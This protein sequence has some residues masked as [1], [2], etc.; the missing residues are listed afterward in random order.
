MLKEKENLLFEAQISKK[1]KLKESIDEEFISF[2]NKNKNTSK[3]KLNKNFT[4]DLK[5]KYYN[6]F[7]PIFMVP[8]MS[9]FANLIFT[10]ENFNNYLKEIT[11]NDNFNTILLSIFVTVIISLISYYLVKIQNVITFKFCNKLNL[12]KKKEKIIEDLFNEQ[13]VSL[14]L[15]KNISETVGE[16]KTSKILSFY[17]GLI[18]N[19][20]IKDIL[21]N[22]MKEIKEVEDKFKQISSCFFIKEEKFEAKE[23]IAIVKYERKETTDEMIERLEGDLAERG[24]DVNELLKQREKEKQQKEKKE[25]E[26]RKK[27]EKISLNKIR[28]SRIIILEDII[29]EY[30]KFEIESLKFNKKL[31]D[32]DKMLLKNI[33]DL[34]SRGFDYISHS[35][36]KE[37]DNLSNYSEETLSIIL[38]RIEDG[39]NISKVL[40]DYDVKI[41]Q[42]N[43]QTKKDNHLLEKTKIKQETLKEKLTRE[44]IEEFELL[45][46][47]RNPD[48]T[49]KEILRF[50]N[51]MESRGFDYF[52]YTIQKE[53]DDINKKNSSIERNKP[54]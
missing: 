36:K 27:S 2:F 10:N 3:W 12:F 6:A 42:S 8:Y 18:R 13:P 32:Y 29:K 34:E 49:E 5:S 47:K 51:E 20:D 44:K 54:R 28:K 7:L 43:V 48:S 9:H 30:V 53:I 26:I 14:N 19:S 33:L 52:G 22:D 35:V 31:N 1:D 50:V 21:D 41:T 4:I 37:V 23:E 15:L 45:K 17:N 39:E 40:R 16:E 25:D 38:N 11:K 46:K 24:V